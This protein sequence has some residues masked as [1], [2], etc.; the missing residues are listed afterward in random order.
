MFPDF[1]NKTASPTTCKWRWVCSLGRMAL[2]RE[3]RSAGRKDNPNNISSIANLQYRFGKEP[4]PPRTE[5]G[6][7]RPQPWRGPKWYSQEATLWNWSRT[8]ERTY[9]VHCT[10]TEQW[11]HA[12]ALA[13]TEFVVTSAVD[14]KG[15]WRSY[16]IQ[17][18]KQAI[19]TRITI[20]WQLLISA[21]KTAYLVNDTRQHNTQ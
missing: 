8:S 1:C 9:T 7:Q 12:T 5:A 15:N 20:T 21:R 17:G 18:A 10:W 6:D 2:R 11:I 4:D 19:Y 3:N 13:Q 16:G 14:W